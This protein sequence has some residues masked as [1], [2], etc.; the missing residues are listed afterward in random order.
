LRADRQVYALA[1]IGQAVP[2]SQS[3]DKAG[4]NVTLMRFGPHGAC[5]PIRRRDMP[6]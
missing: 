6:C 1:Q 5:S 3:R 4:G 2:A